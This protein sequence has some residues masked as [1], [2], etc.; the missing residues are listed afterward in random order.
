MPFSLIKAKELVSRGNSNGCKH[1]NTPTFADKLQSEQV[2]IQ[3]SAELNTLE[4]KQ[5]YQN[6]L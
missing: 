2:S 1:E 3:Y 4:Q 6:Y 5:A